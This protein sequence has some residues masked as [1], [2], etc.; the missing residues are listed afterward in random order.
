[1]DSVAISIAIGI[2]A[3][4]PIDISMAIAVGY[5][6]HFPRVRLG[7]GYRP[8]FGG[9]ISGAGCKLFNVGG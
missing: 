9:M 7:A 5:G 2:A 3:D 4:V 1:M 8:D 6:R